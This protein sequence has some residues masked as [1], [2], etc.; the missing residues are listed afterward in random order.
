MSTLALYID[1]LKY[2]LAEG[3]S[4]P[5]GTFVKRKG[6]T[7][8][9]MRDGRWGKV[10]K[11]KIPRAKPKA[12]GGAGAFKKKGKDS[13]RKTR[14]GQW[15]KSRK[16]RV[17]MAALV[18]ETSENDWKER[19]LAD[20]KKAYEKDGIDGLKKAAYGLEAKG[21]SRMMLGSVLSGI[22]REKALDGKKLSVPAKFDWGSLTQYA[23]DLRHGR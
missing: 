10:Q 23:D 20:L 21:A 18:G 17:E 11:T 8:R 13:Y 7:Y 2:T 19:I 4:L 15:A 3:K 22:A 16:I 9:K 12:K 14:S 6:G 5:V 1:D